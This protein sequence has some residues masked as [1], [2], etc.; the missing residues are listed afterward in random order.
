MLTPIDVSGAVNVK[1]STVSATKANKMLQK[2]SAFLFPP[3]YIISLLRVD[4][5]IIVI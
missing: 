3:T 1:P 2:K 5:S 4:G